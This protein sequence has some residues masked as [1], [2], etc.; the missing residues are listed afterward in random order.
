MARADL[1]MRYKD[2][3]ELVKITEEHQGDV[4]LPLVNEKLK[5]FERSAIM[6]I[7]AIMLSDLYDH[8]MVSLERDISKILLADNGKDVIANR[9]E[10]S[11]LLRIFWWLI[12]VYFCAEY[13][14]LLTK[15]KQV[16]DWHNLDMNFKM[17]DKNGFD[18]G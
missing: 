5:E 4:A 12:S 13:S 17:E 10:K 7:L 2:A 8:D 14:E 9:Q 6:M 16:A 3:W 18:I 1:R 11:R 15:C